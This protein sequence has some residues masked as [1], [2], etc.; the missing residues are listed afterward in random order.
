MTGPEAVAAVLA[1][2]EEFAGAQIR[3][4]KGGVKSWE[5]PRLVARQIEKTSEFGALRLLLP[6][7]ELSEGLERYGVSEGLLEGR[8]PP[9]A[10]ACWEYLQRHLGQPH[11]FL[12]AFEA[13]GIDTN[14]G[15]TDTINL[16]SNSVLRR[17]SEQELVKWLPHKKHE[18]HVLDPYVTS[19]YWFV[20]RRGR[21]L[22]N[23]RRRISMLAPP[24]SVRNPIWDEWWIPFFCLS[25]FRNQVPAG[26]RIE[27]VPGW[28]IR[29]EG[30]FWGQPVEDEEGREYWHRFDSGNYLIAN[31]DR[32]ELE[33]FAGLLIPRAIRLSTSQDEG[34]RFQA[35]GRS[36]LRAAWNL[37]SPYATEHDLDR[38]E[39]CIFGLVR[40][41]DGA[42]HGNSPKP[43]QTLI[44]TILTPVLALFGLR[45]ERKM[46]GL[47]NT[48]V[49]RFIRC[50]ELPK[51]EAAPLRC[52]YDQRSGLAHAY[53]SPE[54]SAKDAPSLWPRVRKCLLGYLG[55]LGSLGTRH[56]LLDHLDSGAPQIDLS[57]K[58]WRLAKLT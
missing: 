53:T 23:Q 35:I 58:L 4:R 56:A 7:D 43:R 2:A 46:L 20:T 27:V 34:R 45:T 52:A 31:E 15:S 30:E 33:E 51:Q 16:S 39:E 49:Q 29:K 24:K 40:S 5:E 54:L 17:F 21:G 11:S 19:Q 13:V 10:E 26:V 41:A 22:F 38:I 36:F 57:K 8:P 25:L 50:A 48:F 18:R 28:S 3:A 12:S 14:D 55:L 1:K 32:A 6:S 47:R 37:P 44:D 42:L 9:T